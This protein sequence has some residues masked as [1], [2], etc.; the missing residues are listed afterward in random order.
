M[1]AVLPPSEVANEDKAT[2]YHRLRRR[3]AVL[4][5]CVGAIFLLLLFVSGWSASLRAAAVRLTGG[6][7]SG[8]V[9]LYVL[10]VA[11]LHEL[12]QLPLAFYEGVTLERRYELS[13]ESTAR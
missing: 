8:T 13:T 2:R 10:V 12:I 5:A 3:A 4:S 6:S 1:A 7:F 9:L 11:L